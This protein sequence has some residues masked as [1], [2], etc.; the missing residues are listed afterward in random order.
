MRG[1]IKKRGTSSWRLIF[2]TSSVNGK[3]KQRTVTV[4]GTYKDAQKELTRL[5]GAADSGMLPD[6]TRMT[7]GEYL[8]AWLGS[9]GEQSPKTL[10]R[11]RELAERQI[12]QHLGDTP[13][14]KLKPEHV[15]AWH[16]KLVTDG[17]SAQTV[18]HAHRVLSLGLKRAV[19]NGTLTRNVAAVR[20]PPTVEAH[21]VEILSPD[22]VTAV[23]DALADHCLYPIAS[24]ALAT[25]CRRGELLALQWPDVDLDRAVLR[26]E[27][28][29][30]ETKAGLRLKPPKTKRGRR[31]IGLPAD[32]VAMLREHRKWQIE[33]RLALGQGGQPVLVFSNVEGAMLS[34]NGV[35][36][37]W[38]Q[39][40]AARKLPRVQFHALRHTHAS[41]LIRAGVDVLTISRRL[42]HSS[43]SMTLDVYGHL[44]EGAD[45]AATK[46]I[47]GVLLK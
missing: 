3:R 6:P 41:T 46:A 25:G 45:A 23:L 29:V 1:S 20:K 43:V 16:A 27:R 44:M 5:L 4:R 13:L 34:P 21:E 30:E 32:A 28:S 15:S 31:N 17:L 42:G 7:V 24:L 9:A 22:Q 10:E 19:E 37:S 38:R 39:T 11:Y 40:C 26:V 33:L 8:R 35:S 14:Q 12:V 18:V 47:E 36:R 2:D